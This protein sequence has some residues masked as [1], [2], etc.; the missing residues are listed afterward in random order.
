M[1][2]EDGIVMRS[3]VPVL[4][5]IVLFWMIFL[6]V[7]EEGVQ[8][9]RL[10]KVLCSLENSDILGTVEV[11]EHIDSCNEEFP[12]VDRLQFD[13]RVVFLERKVQR[14][15]EIDVWS[16]NS[17]HA[18]LIHRELSWVE[19]LWEDFHYNYFYSL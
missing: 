18:L 4:T 13:I 7:G 5:D 17:M 6:V 16:L 10:S 11:P 14:L 12:P 1:L 15:V 3:D 8:R 9:Q 19:V 2:D